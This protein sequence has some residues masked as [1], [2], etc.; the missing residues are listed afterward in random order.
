MAVPR[1]LIPLMSA[2]L[3]LSKSICHAAISLSSD[4]EEW[5]LFA[6]QCLLLK[7]ALCFPTCRLTIYEIAETLYHAMPYPPYLD[8]T[9]KYH[10]MPNRIQT[11]PPC[12]TIPKYKAA[13]V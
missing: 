11:N 4:C 7:T 6:T 3:L 10:A 2:S 1:W 5:I 13:G 8:H 9:M 12:T